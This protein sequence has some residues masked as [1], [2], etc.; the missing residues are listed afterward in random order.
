MQAFCEQNSR[1]K[2]MEDPGPFADKK[3]VY[4]HTDPN[5]RIFGWS[6][7]D[8]GLEANLNST[9]VPL[10]Y[11]DVNRALSKNATHHYKTKYNKGPTKINYPSWKPG[12]KAREAK[13]T[14]LRTTDNQQKVLAGI[15]RSHAPDTGWSGTSRIM[16]RAGDDNRAMFG[17][18]SVALVH[19][20]SVHRAALHG[21]AS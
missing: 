11:C 20:N 7:E 15:K 4:S 10:W 12:A 5:M 14:T 17:K 2:F 9:K 8:A 13:A 6:I 21:V 3:F 16:E 1:E 18:N 19:L